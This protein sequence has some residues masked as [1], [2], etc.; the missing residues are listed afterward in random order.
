M[1]RQGKKNHEEKGKQGEKITA[2][3]LIFGSI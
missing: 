1:A 3:L 2:I